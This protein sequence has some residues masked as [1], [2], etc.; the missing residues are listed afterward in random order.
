MSKELD[1]VAFIGLGVMGYPM[2]GHLANS[3]IAV[4]VYNRTTA[5]ADSGCQSMQGAANVRLRQPQ[6]QRQLVLMWC[7]CVSATMT[8]CAVLPWFRW[9]VLAGMAAG[10]VLVDHTTA[11]QQLAVD[12][13]PQR[14][15]MYGFLM[16][17]YLEA[18]LGRERRA[19]HNV[20]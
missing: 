4:T 1:R 8:T 11:S 19:H 6:K 10:S 16:H 20:R 18:R 14:Q 12:S 2:A 17:P 9:K 5:K 15:R 7:L 13:V 3:G